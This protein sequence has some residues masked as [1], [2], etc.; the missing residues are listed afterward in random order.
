[1]GTVHAALDAGGNRLA[2][3]VVHPA[4]TGDEEFRARFR[5]EVALTSRVSGACLVPVVA[6]GCDAERPWL[7]T[8][9]ISGRTLQERISAHGPL[10]DVMLYALAVGTAAALTSIHE[11]GV[12][13]RDVEPGNVILSPSGPR[14]LDFGI[15]YAGTGRPLRYR[16][17]GHGRLPCAVPGARPGRSARGP[18]PPRGGCAVEGARRPAHRAVSERGTRRAPRAS[19]RPGSA[20]ARSGAPFGRRS[21]LRSPEHAAHPCGPVAGAPARWTGP[22]IQF[23]R[24]YGGQRPEHRCRLH[25]RSPGTAD[26]VGRCRARRNIRFLLLHHRLPRPLRLLPPYPQRRRVPDPRSSRSAGPPSPR[27]RPSRSRRTPA[28]TTRSPPSGN[29]QPRATP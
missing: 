19:D 3:K 15:A 10:Q 14:L 20:T 6:A 2:V 17:P 18:R 8:P 21:G 9:S 4:Q 11:A 12:I 16:G 1:M 26:A 13:H 22:Q 24:R 5:R 25:V 29:G 27:R 23:H 28:A 7:A